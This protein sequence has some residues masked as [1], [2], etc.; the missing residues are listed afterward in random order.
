[1]S[2]AYTAHV[3]TRDG[4]SVR[5]P[6][7]AAESRVHAALQAMLKVGEK[8]RSASARPVIDQPIHT[9]DCCGMKS[10]ASVADSAFG[11]L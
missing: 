10:L 1:V 5:V 11:S 7:P 9:E 6:V 2:T 4:I 3:T 8:S